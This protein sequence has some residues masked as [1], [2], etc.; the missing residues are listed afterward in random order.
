MAGLVRLRLPGPLLYP[1]MGL[2][3]LAV[4]VEVLE[5]GVHAT[6]AGVQGRSARWRFALSSVGA[7]LW[8]PPAGGWP[9]LALVAGVVVAAV[10]AAGPAV[11]A[12]V[13]GLRVFAVSFTGLVGGMVVLAV[14]RWRRPRLP[15]AAP[16]VLVTGGVAASI[17]V[18]VIFLGREPAAAEYL[19]PAA[20]VYLA[21][22]LAGCLLWGFGCPLVPVV[23][24]LSRR[25]R[26]PSAAQRGGTPWSRR[27]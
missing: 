19:P 15:V 2:L 6:I 5:S 23:V 13:P 16:S 17:A 9:V 8:L 12:V 4:G 10:A 14:A 21:A 22:V 18:T 20:A 26:G 24:R 3:A 25:L 1:L 27:R 7:M 11:G